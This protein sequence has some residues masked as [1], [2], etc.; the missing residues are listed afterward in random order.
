[1]NHADRDLGEQVA[2]HRFCLI[3]LAM[4]LDTHPDSREAQERFAAV[5]EEYLPL[6]ESF[7]RQYG[8]LT[9]LDANTDGLWSWGME[10]LP[11]EEGG[12]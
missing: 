3:D 1:M 10:P 2:Y 7:D 12:Q 11:E 5:R 9:L 6:L 4:Y 8:P